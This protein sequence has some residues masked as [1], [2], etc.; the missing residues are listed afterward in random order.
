MHVAKTG[1]L[2]ALSGTN[3]S[4]I[5]RQHL[6]NLRVLLE[7]KRIQFWLRQF[8][9]V[10]CWER[11]ID[12]YPQLSKNVMNLCWIDFKRI[13]KVLEFEY[14][15]IHVS[16]HFELNWFVWRTILNSFWNNQTDYI[17]SLKNRKRFYKSIRKNI[18]LSFR[19]LI[20]RWKKILLVC[21]RQSS[22]LYLVCLCAK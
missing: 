20:V 3:I 13:S 5:H 19:A 12:N 4:M 8:I 15:H 11:S 14:V 21:R 7:Q 10:F 16:S 22:F 6:F 1:V 17:F 18:V 2:H 9:V